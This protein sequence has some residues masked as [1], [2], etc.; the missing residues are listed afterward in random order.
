MNAVSI[1]RSTRHVRMT[2]PTSTADHFRQCAV[3]DVEALAERDSR[4]GEPDG[5]G[6]C[7]CGHAGAGGQSCL[8]VASAARPQPLSQCLGQRCKFCQFPLL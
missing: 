2:D 1:E 6:M 3:V 7:E 5:N 4:I 8:K